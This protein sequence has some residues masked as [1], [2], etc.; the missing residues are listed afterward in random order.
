MTILMALLAATLTWQTGVWKEVHR[1]AKPPISYFVG[2][3][4]FPINADVEVFE[5][6][7]EAMRYRVQGGAGSHLKGVIINE[8]VEFR[9]EGDEKL[10]VRVGG[11]E[12]KLRIVSRERLSE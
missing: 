3:F 2:Q 6:E 12:K 9:L 8:S 7:C 11:K 10:I 4:A 1:E 5:I